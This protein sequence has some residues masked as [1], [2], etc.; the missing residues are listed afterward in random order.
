MLTS[1]ILVGCE[2]DDKE[3]LNG[4]TWECLEEEAFYKSERIITFQETIYSGSYK[5]WEFKYGEYKLSISKTNIG[6]YVYEKSTVI[7]TE[8][9]TDFYASISGNKMTISGTDIV[10]VKK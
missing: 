8:N 4:T 2:K 3:S 9:G 7:F 5:E 6:T 10:Y 1:V